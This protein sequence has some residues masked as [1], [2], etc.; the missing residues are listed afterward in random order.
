M[1][2]NDAISGAILIALA[3]VMITL[4]ATF[5]PFPGQKYGPSLFP[6][7]LGAG[8]ILCGALLIVRG[9]KTR[10]GGEALVMAP[11]W[12]AEPW[13]LVS[14]LLVPGVTLLSILAWD[15]IGFVPITLASLLAMFFWFRVRPATAVFGAIVATVLLQ[16]F[17]GKLMRVPL[18][19]GWLLNLPPGWLKF[20]T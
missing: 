15:K 7:L 18:P 2:T 16:L 13:R 17:F 9:L 20:I 3:L 19:L 8:M 10:R 5:P 1:R 12:L 11:Q 4:T 14:F 6:R